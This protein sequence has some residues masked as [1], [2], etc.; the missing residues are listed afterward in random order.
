M[1]VGMDGM[2]R[3]KGNR[4]SPCILTKNALFIVPFLKI[5]MRK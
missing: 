1:L 3:R 5:P 2:P 4:R